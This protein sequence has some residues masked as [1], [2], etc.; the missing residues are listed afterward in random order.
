MSASG[1]RLEAITRDL[2]VRWQQTRDQWND[3]KSRE[4][5]Q[6]YLLELFASV[7]RAM[8]AI[9]KLDKLIAKIRKDCE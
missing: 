1:S 6:T 9:D 2:Q 4:F 5:E 8:V 7:E 3:A